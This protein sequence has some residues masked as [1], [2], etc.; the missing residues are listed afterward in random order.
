[1]WK[2]LI[3]ILVGY[4]LYRMFMNDRKK[5][6]RGYQEGKGTSHRYRGDGQRPGLRSLY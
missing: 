5:E 3:L 6:R 1:M 4:A 2:W